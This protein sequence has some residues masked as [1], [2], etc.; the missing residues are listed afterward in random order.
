MVFSTSRP[1]TTK[2]NESVQ[3]G[4][5][6]SKLATAGNR[7]GLNIRTRQQPKTPQT[8]ET[9][10]SSA[11]LPPPNLL[12]QLEIR[13]LD[14]TDYGAPCFDAITAFGKDWP[15]QGALTC[16][17]HSVVG[18]GFVWPFCFN[19]LIRNDVYDNKA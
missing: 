5:N 18:T 7:F 1:S 19:G 16:E 17:L 11:F 4:Q 14:H 9:A 3:M 15:G 10:R 12:F 8:K 13:F 2:T 6:H